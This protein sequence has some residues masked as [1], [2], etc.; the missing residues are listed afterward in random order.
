MV[1]V[2]SIL[3]GT[4]YFVRA[5]IRAVLVWSGLL[6]LLS[7]LSM[8]GMRPFYQAQLAQ[9]QAEAQAV[10]GIPPFPH[11][12]IFAL[13]MLIMVVVFVVQ[14]AAVFRAVLFPQESRF[15]F[16]RLGM[17]ELRLLGAMLLLVVGGLIVGVVCT[18]VLTLLVGVLGVVTGVAGT[19]LLIFALFVALFCAMIF[20]WVRLSLVGPMTLVRRQVV[21][22]PAWR[23]SRG[24]FWRLFGAYLVIGLLILAVYVIFSFIQMGP[25]MG[26]MLRPTDPAAHERVL[27]W[28]SAN[29]GLSVRSL[30]L[31]I[32]GGI[33]YGFSTALQGGMVAV[34]TAQLLDVRGGQKLSEVFE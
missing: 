30:L 14:F 28:Q 29:Y 16:L 9:A 26:D 2:G 22:G 12:G 8:A 31:A 1:T 17:D 24:H 32:V 34:A 33:L 4:F 3:S 23:A 11:P 25:I 20:L 27:A 7:L 15:A 13:A 21:I 19:N 10:P 5:N 6:T 18:F